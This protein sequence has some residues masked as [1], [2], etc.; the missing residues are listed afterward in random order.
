MNLLAIDTATEVASVALSIQGRIETLEKAGT[1]QHAQ[2][3]LPM[4][5]SLMQKNEVSWSSLQGIV[6]NNG[7]GSF[8]GLRIACSVTQA[9]SYPHDLP[10]F[11]IT[12]MEGLAFQ[13]QKKHPGMGILAAGDARMQEV[14]WAYYPPNSRLNEVAIQVGPVQAIE[15]AESQPMILVG[16]GLE[17][18][19]Q[20]WSSEMQKKFVAQYTMYPKAETLIRIVQSQ[21]RTPMSA[22][23]ALPLYVRNKIVHSGESNG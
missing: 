19:Q 3:L 2:Y 18:H 5:Q 9:L 4:I 21:P 23:E 8:T 22:V 12:S 17:N 10:I 6:F 20:Y 13:V 15:I 16:W 1:R 11:G 14:Y 7:P